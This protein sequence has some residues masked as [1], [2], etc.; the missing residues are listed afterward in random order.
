MNFITT[1]KPLLLVA[2]VALTTVLSAASAFAQDASPDQ[3]MALRAVSSASRAEVIADAQA[4]RGQPNPWSREFKQV[5]AS[6]QPRATVKAETLRA[7]Q[8]H[9]VI[10]QGEY[11]SI[12]PAKPSQLALASR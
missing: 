10:N 2:A 9:E 8:A 12:G 11:F 5:V 6:P 3:F 4:F 1:Q 7:I